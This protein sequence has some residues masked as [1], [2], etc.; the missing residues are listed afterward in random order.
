MSKSTLGFAFTTGFHVTKMLD[1][2][3]ALCQALGLTMTLIARNP[4]LSDS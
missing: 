2:R 3:E 4:D 1:P